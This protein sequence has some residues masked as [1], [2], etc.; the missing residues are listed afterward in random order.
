MKSQD[1]QKMLDNID[2]RKFW[3]KVTKRII[4]ENEKYAQAQAKSREQG[5][6]VFI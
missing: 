6:R 2:L 1:I 3:K 5:N 4:K